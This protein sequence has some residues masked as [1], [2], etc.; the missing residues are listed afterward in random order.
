MAATLPVIHSAIRICGTA[1]KIPL[2]RKLRRDVASD[3]KI[4]WGGAMIYPSFSAKKIPFFLLKSAESPRKPGDLR[5][6]K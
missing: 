4:H 5:A 3:R 1:P 2:R 6:K